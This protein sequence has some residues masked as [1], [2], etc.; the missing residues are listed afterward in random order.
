MLISSIE[1]PAG[2]LLNATIEEA[3]ALGAAEA[4]VA[5]AIAG[6]RTRAVKMECR[7]RIYAVASAETQTN[8]ASLAA[9]IGAKTASARSEAEKEQLAAFSMAL[10]WVQS[11]RGA[12]AT[13]AAAPDDDI[14][15]D[16]SWPP[17]P[18]EVAALA[19]GF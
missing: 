3:R 16:A 14:L 9:V 15:A 4:D 10:E 2:R 17:C 19:A 7:R 6:E 13:L 8:M 1:T 11:M 18:A 5:A 12:A